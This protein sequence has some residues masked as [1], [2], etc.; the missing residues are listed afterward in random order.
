MQSATIEPQAIARSW[1]APLIRGIAAILFGLTTFVAPAPS[2]WSLIVVFGAYALVDGAVMMVTAFRHR[3]AGEVWGVRLV[4]GVA[5]VATGLAAF[6]WPGITALVLLALVAT[7]AIITGGLQIAA[8]VALRREIDGEWLLALAG[9]ASVAFGGL[10]IAFPKT[11]LLTLVVWIG[12][13]ALV[14]GVLL[15]A[16]SLRMRSWTRSFGRTF[17]VEGPERDRMSRSRP[18]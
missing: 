16:L 6:A 5:G 11:G 2:L 15:V 17:S 1:W 8:A 4:H 9:V 13:F 3:R 10:L 14:L 12:A 7:W 18:V